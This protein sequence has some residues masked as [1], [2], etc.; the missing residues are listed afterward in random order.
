MH[1]SPSFGQACFYGTM[2]PIAILVIMH[3]GHSWVWRQ[4]LLENMLSVGRAARRLMI[5]CVGTK[6]NCVKLF[7]ILILDRMYLLCLP[8]WTWD[9]HKCS[10]KHVAPSLKTK[11]LSHLDSISLRSEGQVPWEGE[12]KCPLPSLCLS[13][14]CK[15][16]CQSC[17]SSPLLPQS[18]GPPG[19]PRN[20]TLSR[21]QFPFEK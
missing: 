3:R 19:G 17:P 12:L 16:G 7:Q 2:E 13:L 20:L 5:L 9:W 8:T 4:K 15:R 1:S 10:L 6:A 21:L 14:L 18:E 11:H